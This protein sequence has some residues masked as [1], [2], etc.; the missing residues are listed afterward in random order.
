MA[1]GRYITDTQEYLEVPMQ[2]VMQEANSI[3]WYQ[4]LKDINVGPFERDIDKSVEGG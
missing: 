4:D 1:N 3:N 2:M